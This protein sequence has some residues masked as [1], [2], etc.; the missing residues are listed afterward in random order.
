MLRIHVL[1]DDYSPL[2]IIFNP[3]YSNGPTDFYPFLPFYSMLTPLFDPTC[4]SGLACYISPT[5]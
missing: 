1:L 3:I 4:S 2:Y 5:A